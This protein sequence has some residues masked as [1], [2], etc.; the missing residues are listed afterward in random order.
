VT[1]KGSAKKNRIAAL[2]IEMNSG[3][4]GDKRLSKRLPRLVE[5]LAQA[6]DKSFPALLN[7]AELEAAYRFFSNEDV[8]PERILEPHR[9]ATLKRMQDEGI[10]LVLHD[11]TTMAFDPDGAREGLGRIRKKGQAFFAHVS[12]AVSADGS[13][14]PLGALGL[15]GFTRSGEKAGNERDRWLDQID[16]VEKYVCENAKSVSLVHV[17]DREADDYQL[18]AALSLEKSKFVIRMK[19]DRRVSANEPGNPRWMRQA[20]ESGCKVEA[21]R[22]VH[23]SSRRTEGRNPIQVKIHPSRVERE[24]KLNI[25]ATSVMIERPQSQDKSFPIALLLNVVRVWEP[26]PP[27]GAE[28]VEWMLLTT[29]PVGTE[30]EILRVVDWY[31]ARWV[32]EEYF[33]AIKTG[34]SYEKR[35]VES[36]AGLMNVLATFLPI[37][38]NLLLLRTVARHAGDSPAG[39][40]LS[41]VQIDVLTADSRAAL[42]SSPTA[43]D[44]LLAVARL[45]GHL[46]RNGDPG[47]LVLSRGYEKLEMLTAGWLLRD[48]EKM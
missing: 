30:E 2:A 40:V 14:R 21:K 43:K 32:I 28:P 25:G 18:L 11:T 15:K 36:Y 27:D 34:C 22:Q 8:T 1:N 48:M 17:A 35:Q 31:R 45:G 42:P 47:W 46:K 38:Y 9:Q 39:S 12:L 44:A 4:F 33:K 7:E 13:R 41:K 10:A 5:K 3:E 37:A 6:P 24:A 16:T 23:L 29:C 20:I 19:H 26:S